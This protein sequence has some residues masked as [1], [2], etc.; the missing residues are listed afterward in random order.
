MSHAGYA[1]VAVLGAHDHRVIHKRK[2]VPNTSGLDGAEPGRPL[3]HE[4]SRKMENKMK[5][6]HETDREAGMIE[7]CLGI[8]G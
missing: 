6:K 4:Q 8:G 3:Y 5:R 7:G 1:P 2:A